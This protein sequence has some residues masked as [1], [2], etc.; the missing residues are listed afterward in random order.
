M[1]GNS[2][3]ELQ[4]HILFH[5]KEQKT[6]PNYLQIDLFHS[7]TFKVLIKTTDTSKSQMLTNAGVFSVAFFF[8]KNIDIIQ[9]LLKE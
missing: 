5:P 6:T 1:N 2:N 7:T 8:L 3:T 9:S 4:I